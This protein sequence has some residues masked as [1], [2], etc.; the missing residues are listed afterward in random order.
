MFWL[1]VLRWWRL[2]VKFQGSV[3]SRC[4]PLYLLVQEMNLG[5]ISEGLQLHYHLLQEVKEKMDCSGEL[6]P[7]LAEL[8]ELNTHISQVGFLSVLVLLTDIYYT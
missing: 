4:N 3:L 7:L 8:S 5:R 1:C 2:A 6:T